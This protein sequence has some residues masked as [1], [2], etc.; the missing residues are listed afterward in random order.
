VG[1]ILGYEVPSVMTIF[2]KNFYDFNG[3]TM[4]VGGSTSSKLEFTGSLSTATSTNACPSGSV[5][6][7]KLKFDRAFTP[8]LIGTTPSNVYAG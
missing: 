1:G 3:T 4:P 5:A 6:N 7:C 2:N 8:L